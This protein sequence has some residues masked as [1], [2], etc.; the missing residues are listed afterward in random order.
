M[1]DFP[2]DQ[3]N[4]D[5]YD[6]MPARKASWICQSC[7]YE[8]KKKPLPKDRAKYYANPKPGKCPRCKSD[9]LAPHGF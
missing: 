1:H 3:D 4:Y 6:Q 9:D 5:P 7:G 2:T 8:D